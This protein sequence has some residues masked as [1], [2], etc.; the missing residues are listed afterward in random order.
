MEETLYQSDQDSLLSRLLSLS[1]DMI[2]IRDRL[3]LLNLINGK[4]KDLLPAS[5]GGFG[6][7]D[8]ERKEY[9]IFL[10]NPGI[11]TGVDE[12]QKDC[13]IDSHSIKHSFIDAVCAS[14]HPLI[15][16]MDQVVSSGKH[17][18]Y[19]RLNHAAG[20]EEM[21]IAPLLKETECIGFLLLFSPRKGA[22]G[23]RSLDMM[24]AVSNHLSIAL[25]NILAY[26]EIRERENERSM[27]LK[28][29]ERQRSRLEQQNQYLQE[30]TNVSCDAHQIVGAANGLRMIFQLAAQVAPS[31]TTVLIQ[32]ETGTG[33][34]L[35]AKA[36]HSFSPRSKELMIKA[37]FATLPAHLIESE[38]FGHEKGSFTGAHE[39]R[40]GKFELAN[41]S[42][43]FLD[44]IDRLPPELQ[45]KLLR[46]LQEKEFERIGGKETIRTD[47]RIIAAANRDLLSEVE[48][49]RFRADL[50]YRLNVFPITL[51]PLRDRREDIPMLVSHFLDVFSRK[52]GKKITDV[53]PAAIRS[54]DL[55][56]WP[57]N[58]RELKNVMERSVIMC[59]GQIIDDIYLG[60]PQQN[61]AS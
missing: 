25:S 48:A 11:T 28:E 3:D 43:L 44:E 54:M 39:R 46:V 42:T 49:G 24:Q 38:L 36:I 41:K 26:E 50:Y 37:N 5:H 60:N 31:D 13:F 16:E 21:I 15:F 47:V 10:C 61:P 59:T 45:I 23:S 32:G 8:R 20:M 22:F 17:P 9:T 30:Q 56:H 35:I 27:L 40:I 55:Y 52:T 4:F 14:A 58:I 6:I 34:E 33:K 7:I 12:T 51:P 1:Q 57:G 53:S 29:T 2:K 19:A 18:L